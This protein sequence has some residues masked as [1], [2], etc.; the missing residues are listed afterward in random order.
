MIYEFSIHEDGRSPIEALSMPDYD[1][2][3]LSPV[4]FEILVRD[5]LQKELK[6]RFESFKAGKDSG[7]DFRY[8]STRRRTLILQCKHYASSSFGAL[9]RELEDRELQKIRKLAPTR[10]LL[11][12]S[13]PL[14]EYQ[15]SRLQTVLGPYVRTS[16]DLY[17]REDLNNLLAR[18]DEIERRTFK[19]WLTSLPVFEEILHSKVKNVSRDALERIRD[20]AKYY[21]QNESFSEGVKILRKHNLCIIAGIPGIGKTILAEMLLLHFVDAEY[22]IVKISNDISE[23]SE[24]NYTDQRRI[25]YYDDFLGQTGSLD[26]FN[27]NEDQNLLDFINTIRTSRVSKLILT[28]R[29]YIL[30]QAKQRYEKLARTDFRIQTCVIDLAKYTRL[31]RARIL[32]NHI[33]FSDLPAPHKKAL[34]KSKGYLKIVDHD[35]YNPRIVKLMTEF[36]RVSEVNA[37]QY[38]SF[39]MSNLKNPMLIWS[40]AFSHQLSTSGKNLLLTL[41]T[42]PAEVF[43]EDCQEAFTLFHRNQAATFG[44]P[45]S[46]SDFI[47]SLKELDGTFTQTEKVRNGTLV[48]FHN[49]SV[50]DFLSNY[51]TTDTQSLASLLNASVFHEQVAWV[52]QFSDLLPNTSGSGSFIAN[53][54]RQFVDALRRTL[55]SKSCSVGNIRSGKELYKGRWYDSRELRVSLVATISGRL[56]SEQSLELFEEMIRIVRAR[57]AALEADHDEL[58]ELLSNMQKLDLLGSLE[59]V[60]L[61][62]EAKNFL[63]RKPWWVRHLEAFCDFKDTFPELVTTEDEEQ[64]K[65]IFKEAAKQTVEDEIDPDEVRSEAQI[66]ERLSKRLDVDIS[67]YVFALEARADNIEAQLPLDSSLD[68]KS[69]KNSGVT[70][71]TDAEID[72]MFSLLSG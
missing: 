22:E 36:S 7:I 17:G 37:Q 45:T 58:V 62:D 55:S 47:D 14:S 60:R 23:A 21:V 29:E 72:S 38:L 30:N 42:L 32:F 68:V 41:A 56:K 5:L 40:H 11:A 61:L 51:L 35:N 52:W 28:T 12:T 70:S 26:K 50:K 71:C 27:K 67:G 63:M 64:I 44:F 24:M 13:L 2:K 6:V 1:F 48:R 19:L 43:V 9:L 49:P 57:V 59:A 18:F 69:P 65:N 34:L 39:F 66:L 53:H 25:F 10:Y 31:N 54:Q 16:G 20:N 15:K 3:T 4:D 8:C 33:Y 46:P